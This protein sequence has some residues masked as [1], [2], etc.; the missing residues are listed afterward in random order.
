[1]H[2][3]L[4]FDK[5]ENPASDRRH[6]SRRTLEPRLSGGLG[7]IEGENEGKNFTVGGEVSSHA[8]QNEA[9]VSADEAAQFL[10]VKRRYLLELARRGLPGA[11]PLGTGTSRKTWVFRLSE[12]SASIV[13]ANSEPPNDSNA[14]RIRS[15]SPR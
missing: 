3:R 7:P 9:F 14:C 1:M 6:G 5:P 2:R 13:A 11:Y 12:L 15:G 8:P 10:S 4:Q